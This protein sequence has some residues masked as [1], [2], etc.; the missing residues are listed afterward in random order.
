MDKQAL[1][2]KI[3][4][5]TYPSELL[6]L[7]NYLKGEEKKETGAAFKPFTKGQLSYFSNPRNVKRYKT[8]CIP[9]KTGGLRE[10][11]APDPTLKS[12]LRY[13]NQILSTLY[14]PS[15]CVTGFAKG[16]SVAD[17]ARMHEHR[18]YVY[19]IDLSNFFPSIDQARVWKRLQ[20]GPYNLSKEVASAIAGLCSVRYDCQDGSARY[21]LPQGAPT[22]PILSNMICERLDKKL[23]GLAK[24]YGVAYSRYADDISFSSDSNVFQ[25]NGRFV[26]LLKKI[27]E[28]EHFIINEKKT[29][30]QTRCVRQEVTGLSVNVRANVSRKYVNRIRTLL[31]L[32]ERYGYETA[33]R[34]FYLTYMIEP[35]HAHKGVPDMVRSLRGK[36]EYMKM[37][38]GKADRTYSKLSDR[39]ALLAESLRNGKNNLSNLILSYSLEQFV[40]AY[41]TLIIYNEKKK[42]CGFKI[43]GWLQTVALSK[44]I[45]ATRF[46]DHLKLLHSSASSDANYVISPRRGQDRYFGKREN[47]F[48]T[49]S[50]AETT[51]TVPLFIDSSE[52]N[53][54]IEKCK[55]EGVERI[56]KTDLIK[57]PE[58]N[59]YVN[60]NPKQMVKVLYKFSCDP[61]IKFY[62]HKPDQY[63]DLTKKLLN[64]TYDELRDKLITDAGDKIN[65]ETWGNICDFVLGNRKNKARNAEDAEIPLSWG[66]EDVRQWSIEHENRNPY[67]A[68]NI[69]G[70]SFTSSIQEFK[71]AIQFRTDDMSETFSR[72]IKRWITNCLRNNQ[73]LKTTDEQNT[74]SED[75]K[76]KVIYEPSF[77]RTISLFVDVRLIFSAL[78]IIFTW[79]NGNK[80][81]GRDVSVSVEDKDEYIDLCIMHAGSY[82]QMDYKKREG[83]DGDFE[84]LRLKLFCVADLIIEADFR[85][86]GEENEHLSSICLGEDYKANYKTKEGYTRAKM[87]TPCKWTAIEQPVGGVRYIIRMYKN[88]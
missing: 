25:P 57:W 81:K 7:I 85:K 45:D 79:I 24:S 80:D 76:L 53:K 11:S 71:H 35:G 27:I 70:K 63:S 10:I 61:D 38:K 75:E 32:W 37:V 19:N 8:F 15:P 17:N 40:K 21:A 5:I 43:G 42:Q 84:T 50:K 72:S 9:K 33:Y 14:V 16:R 78:N 65:H 12:M 62:T 73:G 66:D 26:K 29:R 60:H 48:W 4:D 77:Y 64:I 87:K 55:K 44:D 22:S 83:M 31:Y 20:V 86:D 68:A 88:L 82:L 58:E 41:S 51:K 52:L 30:L 34:R 13:V 18:N 36:L 1:K 74:S 23:S 69:D 2:T 59:T 56:N 39:F 28:E 47:C 49:I 67:Y 3:S 6:E 54:I 46:I